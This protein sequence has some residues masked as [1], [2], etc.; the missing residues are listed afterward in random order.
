M[1]DALSTET[2]RIEFTHPLIV[3]SIT[4]L[5]YALKM[6]SLL[7]IDPATAIL[8]LSHDS[9]A[10]SFTTLSSLSNVPRSTIGITTLTVT[11]PTTRLASPPRANHMASDTVD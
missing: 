10:S 4:E 5:S 2:D 8:T 1:Q 7:E 11:T 3:N 9:E 6:S